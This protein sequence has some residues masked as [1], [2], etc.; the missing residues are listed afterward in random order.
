MEHEWNELFY[1]SH[2]NS[3]SDID[4]RVATV[5]TEKDIERCKACGMIRVT[6]EDGTYYFWPGVATSLLTNALI[7][8][9]GSNPVAS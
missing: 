7:S 5:G 8:C 1:V 9:S 6:R 4:S 2:G 3:P